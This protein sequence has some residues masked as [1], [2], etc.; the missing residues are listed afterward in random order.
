M[1]LSDVVCIPYSKPVNSSQIE[2]VLS[3]TYGEIIRW[4]VIGVTD[5]KLKICLSYI[6]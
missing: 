4:A 5:D 1:I 3:D 2:T 6:K